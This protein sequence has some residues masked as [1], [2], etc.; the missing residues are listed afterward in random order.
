MNFGVW[1]GRGEGNRSVSLAFARR[2]IKSLGLFLGAVAL[3]REKR[4][5]RLSVRC[6]QAAPA[7][8]ISI[9]YDT[10]D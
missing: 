1:V 4:I 10:R 6:T 3:G 9:K 8:R 2:K 5:L 7:G